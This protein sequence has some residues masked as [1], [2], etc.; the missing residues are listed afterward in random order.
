MKTSG[1]Q[2]I[3]PLSPLQ[4]GLLFHALADAP[5]TGAFDADV[6]T[7]Q[8]VLELTGPLA[9]ARLRSA[10]EALLR[11]HANLRASFRLRAGGQP[12]QIVHREVPLP[13][14][15]TDLGPLTGEA[16]KDS[17]RA[18]LAAEQAEP[19]D[20]AAPP[21]LR[22]HLVRHGAQR[23][24]LALTNHHILWDGW[25]APVIQRELLTLYR[26][27]GDPGGLPPVS[28]YS[29][30]LAWLARRDRDVSA[31]AWRQALDGLAGPTL[32]APGPERA[33]VQPA[34]A[35]TELSPELTA[36]ILDGARTD[37]I[38][39]NTL[40]QGVWALT[41]SELTGHQDVVFGS[42]VSGRPP[43]IPGIE[44]MVGLFINTVPVRVRL[45]AAPT[46]TGVLARLQDEQTH[47]LDH[48]Q[49]RLGDVQRI[50]GAGELFD[51]VLTVENYPAGG[52]EPPSYDGV[53]V[54][55]VSGSDAA[56]Y[57]LRLIA[58]L[59]GGRL[60]LRLEHRP[61]LYGPDAAR[62]V[63]DH[64]ARLVEAAADRD[65][66]AVAGLPRLGAQERA[67]LPA[68]AAPE[69]AA[70][71]DGARP[72]ATPHR[73]GPTSPQQEILCGLFGDV[74]GRTGLT[75]DDN[76]FDEGGHSLSALKLLGRVRTV[77]GTSLP[78]REL[79]EAPTP[80]LLA[81]RIERADTGAAPEPTA[82][83]RPRHI[84]L[85]Y[86]Q[87]RLW[88][89][90]RVEGP[91]PA[92]NVPM[93]LRLTG[94]LDLPALGAALGDLTA[95]HESL[96]TVFPDDAGEPRQHI[97]ATATPPLDV[98]DLTGA[99]APP[100]AGVLADA[101][102][103]AFDL[104]GEIPLR[105]TV[106]RLSERE[107]IL[108]LLV[109]HIAADGGSVA[110]LLADLAE[111]Y[112]ARHSGTAP[113]FS[114]LPL[115]YADYTLWQRELLGEEQDPDSLL[116]RQLD[117]WQ[118]A[119]EGAPPQ[120]ELPLDRPRPAA[121]DH[122]GALVDFH[123]DAEAHQRLSELAR[124]SGCTLFMVVQAALSTLLSRMGAGH[125][126]PLGT[127]VAGRGAPELDSLAGFF[128]NTLVLRTDT[129]G[130]P[131]F[132]E[133]LGRV[134]SFDLGAYA[135]QE[136]PFE[137]L[138]EA[139]NP[140]R[141]AA[142]HP[143]F[144][145][146]LAFQNNAAPRMELPG[147]AVG[148]EGLGTG[149]ARCDLSFSIGE[150][151]AEDGTVAGLRGIVEYATALFDADTAQ[152]LADRLALLLGSAAED[153]DRRLSALDLLS[154]Q[155]KAAL[156]AAAA[157][158]E[159]ITPETLPALF[160]RQADSTPLAPAVECGDIVLS[161]AELNS[162]AEALAARLAALGAGPEQ[163]VALALPTSVELAVAVLAVA[164]SGAAYVPLDPDYPAQR[165]ALMLADTRPRA[166]LTTA[167]LAGRLPAHDTPTLLLDAGGGQGLQP[168]DAP[169][170]QPADAP[171]TQPAAS[172]EAP[173]ADP[174]ETPPARRAFPALRPDHPAYVIYTSGSTGTPKGV[175]VT[176][177]G[178]AGLA[179]D[180]AAVHGAGPGSR[181]LQFVSPSFDVSVAEFCMALL[182]GACLV[183]PEQR[184]VGAELA[185]FLAER[186]ISH[187]HLPPA[188]L[189]G[190]PA[191]PLP[192]LLTLMS[193]G[194]ASSPTLVDRWARGRRMINAYGPT[195]AT[196]EVTYAVQDPD[197][198]EAA[199]SIGR[200]VSGVRT[201]VLDT[202]LRPVAPGAV[203]ELYIAG[204]GIARGYLHR[205]ALTAARFVAAPFGT[206][207][208]RMYRTGDLVRSRRDGS[209]DFVGRAD[210]QI[211]LRGFRIERGEIEAA[212]L[213]GPEV[214]QAAVVVREDRPGDPRLV[215]YLVPGPDGLDPAGVLDALHGRL[216]D[217]MIPSAV[218]PLEEL[219]LTANGKL[220]ERA[221]PAPVATTGSGR[222][223]RTAREDTLCRLFAEVLGLDEAGM[224]D[225]FFDLGGHSLLATK[226][227]ALMGR[228][229]GVE[230]TVR[231][232]FEAPTPALLLRRAD[233]EHDAADG[234]APLL[235]LRRTGSRTPLFCVHPVS[236]L[237][238]SYS[239]LL[240]TLDPEQPLYGL[241]ANG[242]DGKGEPATTLQ[243]MLDG[244]VAQLRTVQPHGPYRLLGWSLGGTLAHLIAGELQRL[245]EEVEQV[246]LLDAYPVEEDKRT[247]LPTDQ[248]LRDL[249]QAYAR[250]HGD[251]PDQVPDRVAVRERVIGYMGRGDSEL[252]HLDD[253]GRGRVLD[254]LVNNVRLVSP[255]RPPLFKGDLLLVAATENVRPW[256][257][258]RAWEPYLSGVTERF[259]IAA[260][261][262]DLLA[263]EPAAR[264]GRM[265]SER[266]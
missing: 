6:Y 127:A 105:A 226:L 7:T 213:A 36:R 174:R 123:L 232:V 215:A 2:D 240:R 172:Q 227:A 5:D 204:P 158:A 114:P 131:T 231:D 34:Y 129:S 242:L 122:R 57:P 78:V 33:P 159:A 262:E 161:Y 66:L 83:P 50:A 70:R 26:D 165:L 52:Q 109:H 180:S 230:S 133:L 258:Q 100:A 211:K 150:T 197:R 53:S 222:A 73:G 56:H 185:R 97:L 110:P 256:A 115:Q 205:A 89:L 218:V 64:V 128:V 111:A 55:S 139:M 207:G 72:A 107:H 140:V 190:L 135:H 199:R 35:E 75:P 27:H 69:S 40:L 42:V 220:D 198:P 39:L 32:V 237:S 195:E 9:P 90:H 65:G 102:R 257:D 121:A 58:G 186:R 209:L 29:S 171:P 87:Q 156:R 151:H 234:F 201:Y 166:V 177:S 263:P 88:F 182:T 235:M 236:G 76:F 124:G 77:F 62:T 203:G 20:L 164:K 249:F 221:L 241:Q 85:S 138:V 223:P 196:V 217:Y 10:A 153:P 24:T 148:F 51:T 22:F 261:H 96:R 80:A 23:H 116:S 15:E 44:T 206:P 46:L 1:L 120:I 142:V 264:I 169:P 163:F 208:E 229:L 13:W 155:E 92:Y 45:D 157:D 16:Q 216:P 254:V 179:A 108:L 244:Y 60:L 214:T 17:L 11:R 21:A 81:R 94:R 212:L 99:D 149:T 233:G 146:M 248:V 30:Y 43:E 191:E 49:L 14:R 130:D 154:P 101:A 168:A 54:A 132:R 144:Q 59:S 61:D 200:P 19:F 8:M 178:L 136:L 255:A 68:F 228:V 79:F 67:V 93:P 71:S 134:R 170:T 187:A 41:L 266:L 143:L 184:H 225:N 194:E 82:R 103:H 219:P 239:T 259:E 104:T 91:S 246:V 137:R 147:L 18:L 25:S 95:R 145:V 113:T 28:P 106:L 84:P 238:W 162:R 126:I 63:L 119:L 98:I 31:R 247:E 251:D 12:L 160:A 47:L 193:G 181:V 118:G 125:D 167:G 265:L 183:I 202:A 74:L 253:D 260:T 243:E 252:R 37:G 141:T 175:V 152:D 173:P 250:L 189:A 3:L 192:G 48:Q 188:V 245:G 224:D 210:G 112:R 86:A 117:Y 176:H 4:E 38:T